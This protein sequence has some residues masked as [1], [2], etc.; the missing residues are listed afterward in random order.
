[1]P[2][3]KLQGVTTR[4]SLSTQKSR[5]SLSGGGGGGGGS[6]PTCCLGKSD[7]GILQKP[8]RGEG[9]GERGEAE[10]KRDDGKFI[11]GDPVTLRSRPFPL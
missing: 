11:F 6:R 5:P 3:V 8:G 9:Q 2:Q 1:M 10:G 4:F 7:R